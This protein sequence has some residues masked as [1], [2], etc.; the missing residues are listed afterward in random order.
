MLILITKIYRTR[1]HNLRITGSNFPHSDDKCKL[2]LTFEPE[3]FEGE[4][5]SLN[6]LNSNELSV[7]LLDNRAWMT[8]PGDLLIKSVYLYNE[9]AGIRIFP[10]R[11]NDW[12]VA[13]VIDHPDDD[14]ISVRFAFGKLHVCCTCHLKI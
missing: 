8:E 3:L 11:S 1:S 13:E 7:S 6:F 5:Y 9:S 14:D 2:A 4:D 12:Q 10:A